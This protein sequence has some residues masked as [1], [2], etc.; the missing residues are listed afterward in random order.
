V[1]TSVP[2]LTSR[3]YPVST[4]CAYHSRRIFTV[5]RAFLAVGYAILAR[6]CFGL[7]GP[8]RLLTLGNTPN[9]KLA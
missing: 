8:H 1:E 2:L 4:E 9:T 5:T 6:T 3:S 7:C